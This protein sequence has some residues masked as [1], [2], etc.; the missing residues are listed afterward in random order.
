V[1]RLQEAGL[2]PI[3]TATEFL[4]PPRLQGGPSVYDLFLDML[5]KA[6]VEKPRLKILPVFHIGKLEDP[7]S[8]GPVSQAMMAGI[9]PSILQ[10]S[11]TRAVTAQGVFACPILVGK[12]EGFLGDSSLA[13]CPGVD[14]A[15]HACRTCYE[16]GM[17]CANT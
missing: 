9:D 14:L 12:K 15:H 6:G 2:L 7:A 16:T 1:L 4:L 5:R 13:D 3:V 10:C 11:E 17:S 8:G